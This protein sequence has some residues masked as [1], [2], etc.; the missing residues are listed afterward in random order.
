MVEAEL[1]GAVELAGRPRGP[2]DGAAERVG[3]LDDRGPDARPDRVHEHVLTGLEPGAGAH[4]VVG[5][6]EDL[7]DPAGLDEVE[8]VG[9]DR[10]VARVHHELLG[11]R[12]AADDAEDPV[13]DGEGV[14]PVAERG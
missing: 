8:A 3:E 12:A 2:G 7:G 1:A 4:R 5:G 10:A 11:L 9:D 14:D 6:D 13:A